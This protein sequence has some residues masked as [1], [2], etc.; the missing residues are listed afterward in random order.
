MSGVKQYRDQIDRIDAEIVRLIGQRAEIAREIAAAKAK[1][2]LPLYQPDREQQVYDKIARLNPGI[3]DDESLRNIYR[4]IMSATLKLEGSIQVGYFGA[5]GS[6]THQAAL[7]KFGRSLS[8]AP[9]RTI[10]DV[11]QAVQRREIKYGVVPIENSTEGMVKATLDALVKF[12]LN[13][14][15]DIVLQIRQSLLTRATALQQIEKIY[16]HPQAYAQARNFIMQNLPQAEWIETASTSEAVRLVAHENSERL[17]AIASDVAG[18]IY[19]LRPLVEDITDYKRNFT[20]FI[21]IG[22]D[23]AKKAERNR[24]MISFNLPDTT[25]SLYRA[26]APLYEQKVNMRAIES[27][28]DRN[29]VW[30]YIFFV[31]LEGHREDE[32]MKHAFEL[33]RPLTSGFRVLGSYPV[34]KGPE[35]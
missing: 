29:Q 13:I 18:E 24:T 1:E 32:A 20:R 6:F 17:A 22:H 7:R 9:F 16:T 15:S 12:D 2:N 21:V 4:E 28:P 23:V 10:D 34:E 30:S 33:M 31:D 25:G 11:F 19:G 8:L 5:E 27:R 26:L 3:L 14:Y 35:D